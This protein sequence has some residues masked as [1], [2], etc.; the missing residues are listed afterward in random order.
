VHRDGDCMLPEEIAW[1]RQ[2]EA[3]KMPGR[4]ELFVTPLTDI[5]HQ[6]CQAE[7]LAASLGISAQTAR[8]IINRII[9]ANNASFAVDFAN[10][11]TDLRNKVLKD[12][13]D[14]PSAQNLMGGLIEFS[15]IKGKRLFGILNTELPRQGYNPMHLLT[16]RT[17]AL[18]IEELQQ[19]A[20]RVWP[21]LPAAAAVPA[22]AV[23]AQ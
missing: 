14:V 22:I 11:R 15:Q 13:D 16:R 6:F 2:R 21:P 12:K 10:K 17:G 9:E 7:H 23:P 3:G 1:Y 5:E 18:R 4:C 8:D 19:F 20:E